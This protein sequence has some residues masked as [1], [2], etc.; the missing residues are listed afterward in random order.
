MSYRVNMRLSSAETG[1]PDAS[2]RSRPT[3]KNNWHFIFVCLGYSF[4]LGNIWIFPGIMFKQGGGVFLI[5][6]IFALLF[7]GL[8]MIVLEL[9]LG[10]MFQRGH[11]MVM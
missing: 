2:K 11:I 6:Y 1:G 8:P 4:G 9:G 7:F 3:Y 10:Q 5:P